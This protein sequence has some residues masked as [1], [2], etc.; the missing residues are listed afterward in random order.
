MR[1]KDILG[2]FITNPNILFSNSPIKKLDGEHEAYTAIITFEPGSEALIVDCDGE[3]IQLA[4]PGFKWLMYLPMGEYWSLTAFYSPTGELLEFYFD[5]TR[6]NFIDERGTP[7]IDDI[8]LDLVV[9][10]NGKVVTIDADELQDALDKGEITQQEFDNA[11]AVH[12]QIKA[13]K[14]GNAEFLKQHCGK[15]LEVH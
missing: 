7:C 5:I 12:D 9:L 3:Q 4:G 8:F 6:S 13:S 14:W 2:N 11:Y 15:L 1:K 10:P